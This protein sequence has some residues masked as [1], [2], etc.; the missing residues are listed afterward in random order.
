M[1]KE[2]YLLEGT[3]LGYK[4]SLGRVCH[5][6]VITNCKPYKHLKTIE[7]TD[8]TLLDITLRKCLPRERI[9]EIKG[10]TSLINKA[11]KLN[12]GFVS[13]LELYQKENKLLGKCGDI[14]SVPVQE[15][16]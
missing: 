11:I 10:Y 8:N 1:R 16:Q 14:D 13:V 9:K 4:S 12:K 15:K 6:V 7:F 3:W 2:R 5:R